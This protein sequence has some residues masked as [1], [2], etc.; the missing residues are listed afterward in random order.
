M[1]RVRFRIVVDET[2][3]RK[4]QIDP[5]VWEYSGTSLLDIREWP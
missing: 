5:Y 4:H 2:V 3:R 1:V